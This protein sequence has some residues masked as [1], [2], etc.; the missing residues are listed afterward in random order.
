MVLL[1]PELCKGKYTQ[2]LVLFYLLVP[3]QF[4]FLF[5]IRLPCSCG[6]GR[7][8]RH[9][10]T[11][12]K[13]LGDSGL[14]AQPGSAGW[15][16]GHNADGK[17]QI[18]RLPGV[19]YDAVTPSLSKQFGEEAANDQNWGTEDVDLMMIVCRMEIWAVSFETYLNWCVNTFH[20]QPLL[21]SL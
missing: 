16:L 15:D 18:W 11:N 6:H 13:A 8:W 1:W 3:P 12:P 10:R 21:R 5:F 2:V 17:A 7:V 19:W 14:P 9:A 20:F 4:V